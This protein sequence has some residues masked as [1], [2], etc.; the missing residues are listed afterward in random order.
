MIDG[1]EL[2]VGAQ[3]LF[4]YNHMCVTVNRT[5]HDSRVNSKRMP[6]LGNIQLF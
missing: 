5:L 2:S 6:N 3:V 1:S 4:V